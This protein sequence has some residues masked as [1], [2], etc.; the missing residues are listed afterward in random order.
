MKNKNML[1]CED[2][3]KNISENAGYID[4]YPYC[5]ECYR[6]NMNYNGIHD[7]GYRPKPV[8]FGKGEYYKITVD[9]DGGGFLDTKA[10]MLLSAFNKKRG[11]HMYAVQN[12]KLKKGFSLVFS[13]MTLCYFDKN[14][15]W[16]KLKKTV[17]D[18]GYRIINVNISAVK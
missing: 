3:G 5:A 12:E 7:E 13:P 2:C 10:E 16:K 15:G 6:H 4:G 1:I 17:F 8:F 9:I 14:I 11:E 18:M